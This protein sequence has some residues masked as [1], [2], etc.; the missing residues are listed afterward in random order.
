MIAA[1]R[2]TQE[3]FSINC[4]VHDNTL[5]LL[6][7]GEPK[8]DRTVTAIFSYL[9]FRELV[10]ANKPLSRAQSKTVEAAI[11]EHCVKMPP[12]MRL[13]AL[14]ELTDA[15][16]PAGGNALAC[17]VVVLKF[18]HLRDRRKGRPAYTRAVTRLGGEAVEVYSEYFSVRTLYFRD[19]PQ[20]LE[21]QGSREFSV[22]DLQPVLPPALA[23]SVDTGEAH[24]VAHVEAEPGPLS[25]VAATILNGIQA[26]GDFSGNA[27]MGALVPEKCDRVVLVVD[28]SSIPVAPGGSL[29]AAPPTAWHR[30]P[31]GQTHKD[32]QL[33]CA[34][35]EAG[36]FV[37]DTAQPFGE[38]GTAGAWRGGRALRAS[39]QVIIRLAPNWD[40][41]A[42]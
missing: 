3:E 4:G 15:A 20:D 41:L 18:V 8:A 2:L 37:I 34:K 16:K 32:T 24:H 6:L 26:D 5:R 28:L 10:E 12:R 39:D 30:Q 21:L 27:A 17:M 40:A 19:A 42:G 25:Q 23:L 22:M 29:H 13:N 36:A 38:Q 31:V 7:G 1:T 11:E 35:S 33:G 14:P 9:L